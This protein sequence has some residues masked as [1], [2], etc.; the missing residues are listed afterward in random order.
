MDGGW[1]SDPPGRERACRT[2]DLPG[3]YLFM[4]PPIGDAGASKGNLGQPALGVF[5]L[6]Y[7]HEKEGSKI[8][9]SPDRC[10]CLTN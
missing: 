2:C 6:W 4:C 9:I 10:S 5:R 7:P 1:R 3:Y 8:Q